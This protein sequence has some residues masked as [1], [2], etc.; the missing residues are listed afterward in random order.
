MIKLIHGDCLE[1]MK[2]ISKQ[3]VDLII[4]DPPYNINYKYSG[5]KDNMTELDYYEWQVKILRECERILKTNGSLFYLNYP[6]FNSKIYV[7]LNE[8]FNLKPIEI[9]A[10][11]Y[12]THMGGGPL[13]KAFRTW[14]W[15]SCGEPINNF[16]GE[17]KNPEDKRVK[18][19]IKKG[20]KPREYDWWNFQQ[21]KNVN[22]EKTSHPC[23]LPLIMIKKIINA[24]TQQGDIVADL[25]SG[26]GTTVVGC[27]DL[28]RKC[29]AIETCKEYFEIM[30]KRIANMQKTFL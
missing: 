2:Q 16:Y 23:Q 27:K 15:A 21:V 5:Y 6:E 4:A 7:A 10:W 17:Y 24:T 26:S 9:I 19:M 18:T 14:I 29:I 12:N 3:S 25:F 28:N 13:R 22:K 11:I 20:K 30:K 1:K 8:S